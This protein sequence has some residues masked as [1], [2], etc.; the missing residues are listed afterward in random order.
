MND[1]VRIKPGILPTGAATPI[2]GAVVEPEPSL[3]AVLQAAAVPDLARPR[4]GF[5]W[6]RALIASAVLLVAGIGI[7]DAGVWIDDLFVRSTALGVVGTALFGA[8]AAALLGFAGS[9][10]R[11]LLRLRS[12]QGI[13]DQGYRLAQSAG[14]F[15]GRGFMA[16]L[17]KLT[18][19]TPAG[20][21]LCDDFRDALADTH[22]DREALQ[23][24]ERIVLRPLDE[25][26]YGAIRRAARDTAVGAS[27][28][29]VGGLD[30][31]IVLW[32]SMRMVREIAEIYGLRPT[33]L[34]L[35]ALVRRM[36]V[37][38]AFSV[39]TDM[40]GDIVGA[41]LGGRVAGLVSGKLAE[42]IYAG[43]RTG[44]LGIL[45]IEQCRPLP[46]AADDRPNL[47]QLVS[48]SLGSLIASAAPETR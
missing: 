46:F 9:E 19:A 12:A 31:A 8:V 5:R 33:R 30:A 16:D 37:T 34:S 13:R 43:V 11:N 38:A 18:S 23:L 3:P 39:T 41:H 25:L 4:R 29:P 7:I 27:I 48:Q 2:P 1:T 32:R 17:V 20:G 14:T 21:A 6:G 35:F 42:G 40:V 44:R 15:E 45:A 22:D 28:S 47:R 26:A 24:F 36:I 10:Y